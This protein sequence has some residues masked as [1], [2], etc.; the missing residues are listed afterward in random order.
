MTRAMPHRGPDDEG[1]WIDAEAGIGLGHRRLAI[2]DL[3]PRGPPADAVAR[4]PLRPHASTAKSTTMPRSAASWIAGAAPDG[5]LAR[6]FRHGDA[7][8]SDRRT[9]AWAARSSVRVGMFAFGLWDRKERKLS[10]ARDRF[11]EKPLYYGWVGGD[12]VFAS[13]LKAIRQ[14][15]EFDARGRPPGAAAFTRRATTCRRR[16]RSIAASSSF[17]PGCI[18]ELDAEAARPAAGRAATGRQRAAVG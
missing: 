10:L 8:R 7:D 6:P 3:S 18:L 14:H 17:E 9:G 15:P 1:I 5:R 12:L 2:V 13:E 4:R 16:C 11:G